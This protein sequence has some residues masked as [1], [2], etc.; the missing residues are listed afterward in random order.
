MMSRRG[1]CGGAFQGWTML[2]VN[3]DTRL[4]YEVYSGSHFVLH[5]A[6]MRRRDQCVYAES[7][8]IVQGDGERPTLSEYVDVMGN[9]LLRFDVAGGGSLAVRYHADVL[10]QPR[11]TPAE[12]LEHRVSDLPH[13][14]LRWLIPS[15]YSEADLLSNEAIRL[16]GHEPPGAARVEA[17]IRWVRENIEYKVGTTNPRTTA[18]EVF[19]RRVGVCRDYAHLCVAFCRALNLPARYVVGYVLFD[20]PPQDFHA[21]IEVWLGAW[22]AFDPT[23][24][25]PTSH[26]VIVGVGADAKDVSFGTLYGNLRMTGME[27]DITE[28]DP[29]RQHHRVGDSS[30]YVLRIPRPA[31]QQQQISAG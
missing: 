7:F 2:T 29:Q 14:V 31:E 15:R 20:E 27:I 30:S 4:T 23:G 5:I 18:Y 8:D 10:V 11:P 17:V 28:T 21:L 24:L 9:R 22:V 26:V 19:E 16:F 1:R 25:A 3:I 13:E 6:A 12:A